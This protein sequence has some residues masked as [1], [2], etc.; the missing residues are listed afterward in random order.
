M[1]PSKR[2]IPLA[3]AIAMLLLAGCQETPKET[4]KDVAAARTEANREADDAR[5]TA[6]RKTAAADAKVDDAQQAYG[7][8]EAKANETL[9]KARDEAAS[10]IAQADYDRALVE[11]DG[12]FKV[13]NEK[14]DALSGT[15]RDACVSAAESALAVEKAAAQARR[16]AALAVADPA[17]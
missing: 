1:K 17:R 4:A 16:D 3:A 11:A 13:E 14:C 5:A 2:M 6:D 12:R 8:S 7:K 15:A 10:T 9:D